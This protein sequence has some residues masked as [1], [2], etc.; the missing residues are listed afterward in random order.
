LKATRSS[1]CISLSAKFWINCLCEH[2]EGTVREEH[3]LT[4]LG[5]RH[6]SRISYYIGSTTDLA[7]RLEQHCNGHTYS[8]RRLGE[9]LELMAS[10]E[11]LSLAVA[12]QI[13]REMKRKK[14]PR[15]A[16]FLLE[17]YRRQVGV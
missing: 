8:T 2:S 12:R 9:S 6:N 4:D 1:Q 15:L 16:L 17:E 5:C 11:V 14:N 3:L 13:E 10:A 7:R